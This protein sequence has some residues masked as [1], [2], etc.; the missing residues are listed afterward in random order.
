MTGA[1]SSHHE[2]HGDQRV[3]SDVDA[4]RSAI[5]ALLADVEHVGVMTPRDHLDWALA[6]PLCMGSHV[7][8][9]C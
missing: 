7:H 6:L 9:K 2:G 5:D 1:S 3:H 4:V 8:L